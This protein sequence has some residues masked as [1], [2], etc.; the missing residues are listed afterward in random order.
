MNERVSLTSGVS[1]AVSLMLYNQL[2]YCM[3]V[4]SIR[5]YVQLVQVLALP[6]VVTLSHLNADC[7]QAS[8]SLIVHLVVPVGGVPGLHT[9]IDHRSRTG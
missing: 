1:F 6:S 3:R 5:C 8:C 2:L 4:G 7:S 9:I